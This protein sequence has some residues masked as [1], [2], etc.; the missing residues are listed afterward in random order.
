MS[1][2]PKEDG[3]EGP[4]EVIEKVWDCPRCGYRVTD[5]ELKQAAYNYPCGRCGLATL[6]MFRPHSWRRVLDLPASD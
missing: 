4:V 5:A 6:S 2:A 1:D 3:K